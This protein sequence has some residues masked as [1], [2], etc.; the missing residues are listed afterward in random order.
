V[1]SL[2][3]FLLCFDDV[4]RNGFLAQRWA[5]GEYRFLTSSI[6]STCT[7][8]RRRRLREAGS[9]YYREFRWWVIVNGNAEPRSVSGSGEQRGC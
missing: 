7:W 1:F 8:G 4:T 3:S 5:N 9:C 2:T 6:R